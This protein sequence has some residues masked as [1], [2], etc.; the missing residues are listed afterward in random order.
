MTQLEVLICKLVGSKDGS[1]AGT[2]AIDEISTLDHEILDLAHL[3]STKSCRGMKAG[4][5]DGASSILEYV[6]V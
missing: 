1:R 5:E 4:L 3:I 6:E 2:V